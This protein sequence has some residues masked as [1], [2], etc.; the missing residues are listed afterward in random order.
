MKYAHTV[1]FILLA[2]GGLAWGIYGLIGLDV[3][4]SFLGESIAKIVYIL[5]GVAAVYEVVTHKSR[6]KACSG[7]MA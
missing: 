3:V 5:V 1:S 4:Y 6:C 7:Q 2:V